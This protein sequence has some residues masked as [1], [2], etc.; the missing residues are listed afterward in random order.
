MT[1]TNFR[2]L[3]ARSVT[4]AALSLGAL[5]AGGGV[6]GASEHHHGDFGGGE[7]NRGAGQYCGITG[8]VSATSVTITSRDGTVTTFSI[9]PST[10]FS[11][12]TTSATSAA[13]MNGLRVCVTPSSSSASTAGA[14]DIALSK[15]WGEVTA[16]SGSTI[17]VRRHSLL[18]ENVV[19][20]SSTSFTENGAPAS[21]S[22]VTVGERI[23]AVGVVDTTNNVLDALAVRIASPVHTS[24][25]VGKVASVTGN[26]VTVTLFNGLNV[27]VVVSATTEYR[28]GDQSAT[29]ADVTAGEWIVA[30][31]TVDTSANA[32][33]AVTV[34]I[35]QGRE[36]SD[37][38]G[39][40]VRLSL[41]SSAWVNL[42]VRVRGI[43]GFFGG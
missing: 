4:A 29:L 3:L 15:V 27:T 39:E 42:G 5:A 10:T 7:R 30:A 24:Y 1:K 17:T 33:D 32:L 20:S 21:L 37:R 14:I 11:E 16:V 9:G 22:S 6:A 26:D 25:V 36:H 43:G 19:V 40:G 31:G 12:G 41:R 28:M 34:W 8:A 38:L 2:G 35:G 23:L 18:T 13:L